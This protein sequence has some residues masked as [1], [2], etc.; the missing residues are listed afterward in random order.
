MT[1]SSVLKSSATEIKT[2]GGLQHKDRSELASQLSSALANSYVL[3]LKT[4][5]FHW[6]VVGPLFYSLHKLTEEQYED[7]ALAVDTIAER[8]RAI[9]F[10]APGSFEQFKELAEIKEEAGA[11][12]AEEM[13]QQLVDDNTTCARLLRDTVIEAEKVND[14]TTAGILTDRIGQHEENA[15]ML[16]AILS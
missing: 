13:I 16:Q 1:T 3:Y 8:I 10:I 2:K 7:M 15:W 4:Q 9:G 14:V 12:S 11:P 6:N 5:S